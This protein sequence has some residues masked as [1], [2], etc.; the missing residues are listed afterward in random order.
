[1]DI[2]AQPQHPSAPVQALK[3][4]Q[5]RV[6]ETDAVQAQLQQLQI[7]RASTRQQHPDKSTTAGS[8]QLAQ[9]LQGSAAAGAAAAAA[10]ADAEDAPAVHGDDV[11]T[12]NVGGRLFSCQRRTLCL[13]EESLLALMFGGR[14]P[15]GGAT[16]AA[17]HVFLDLDPG[18]FEVA[19]NWLRQFALARG[20]NLHEPQVPP[21]K[22]EHMVAMLDYLQLHRHI[23]LTY[24]EAFDAAHAS[25]FMAVAG[26]TATRG[27]VAA[28]HPGKHVTR[29]GNTLMQF[30]VSDHSYFDMSLELSLKVTA[31][32]DS[33]EGRT[34]PRWLFVGFMHRAV[35]ATLD[36]AGDINTQCTKSPSCY[37]WLVSGQAAYT[38]RHGKRSQHACL[39]RSAM[40]SQGDTLL[41]SLD[42]RR[43][44]PH[45]TISLLNTSTN[46]RKS[47]DAD[48]PAGSSSSSSSGG[49]SSKPSSNS[50]ASSGDAANPAA[51]AAAAAP[52]GQQ[53]QHG[54]RRPGLRHRRAAALPLLLPHGPERD[55]I[56]AILALQPP[57]MV[58]NA[59]VAELV[60]GAALQLLEAQGLGVQASLDILRRPG[61]VHRLVQQVQ[62]VVRV[63]PG[64]RGALLPELGRDMFA[65]T[66][67]A[68]AA[69]RAAG[70]GA[71][72]AGGAAAAGGAGAAAATAAAAAAGGAAAADAA[73]DQQ[74]QQ[75][76]G[77]AEGEAAAAPAAATAVGSSSGQPRLPDGTRLPACSAEYEWVFV[78]GLVQPGDS[79]ELLSV[80]RKGQRPGSIE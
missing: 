70:G 38:V 42:T 1:M 34:P 58:M 49:G 79:V 54:S 64:G 55:E 26:P 56:L 37:G 68:A 60:V 80:R 53:Q 8:L 75:Q 6:E 50:T 17:G 15:G 33:S 25:P 12:L 22:L 20:G 11:V 21:E 57:G 62:D 40:F 16:D 77:L 69:A 76:L 74:Q 14:W 10:A 41:L 27:T 19:L 31:F 44:L 48:A 36:P 71:G 66:A 73:E 29:P 7:S 43:D 13:V 5:N 78:V 32:K 63:Q 35:A 65:A 18:L 23:P 30:S 61:L 4:Q 3:A 47:I 24:R 46:L 67:A 52:N 59:Q 28:A 2:P 39:T 72:G 9:P 51:A 45:A